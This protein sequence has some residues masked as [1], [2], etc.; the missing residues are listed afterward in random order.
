MDAEEAQTLRIADIARAAL[1]SPAQLY[2]A[3]YSA[4]G[5]S[6]QT[7]ARMRKLSMALAQVKRTDAGL[8]DIAQACGYASQQAFCKSVK[9]ATGQ[10][11]LV[12]RHAPTFFYFPPHEANHTRPCAVATETLPATR[13]LL[14][15]SAHGQSL[16]RR[17]V[18][19]FFAAWPGYD[20]RLFGR[21][22]TL[23]D[24]RCGYALMADT[25]GETAPLADAG[26]TFGACAAPYTA[27]FAKTRARDDDADIDEAWNHLHANWLSGSAFKRAD[28]PFFEEYLHANGRVRGLALYLPVQKRLSR[29]MMAITHRDAQR[30]IVAHRR[31]SDA[32]DRAAHDV[33]AWLTAHHPHAVRALQRFYVAHGNGGCTCGVAAPDGAVPS[34][35]DSITLLDM[36][37]GDYAVLE[38]ECSGDFSAY[39]RLLLAFA[40][41]YDLLPDGSA[42]PFAVF[43][44]Q[45]DFAPEATRMKVLLRVKNDKRG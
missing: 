29:R 2:R 12:Y 20:G 35:R 13:T 44:T 34:A 37:G 43:E 16:E 21:N 7:Y 30:F 26:F 42:S 32:E 5:H 9:A 19:A 45:Q 38:G 33:M 23:L 22:V 36:P 6:V 40:R 3:V 10:S 24:G 15:A 28:A 27:T 31:G 18:S 41:D 14:Y 11:P 25:A 1:L 4:T 39:E 8:A 17:A